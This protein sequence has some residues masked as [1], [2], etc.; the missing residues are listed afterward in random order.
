MSVTINAHQLRRLID[1]TINH[2]GDEDTEVL[3]G[4]R[5]E[6]DS[7]YLYAVASDRYTVAAARYRHHGLDGEPF[8]RTLPASCL[9]ALREW[10]DAQPGSDTIIIATKDGRLW[11]TAPNSELAIGVNSQGYFDWRGVLRGVLEQ[12]NG[13]ENAFPV[14]DTRLLAR[15]AAADTTLRFRVT[16]DQQGVLVVGKDFLGAQAPINA[17]RAR[18][19]ADDSLAT[20]DHVHATW[21]HTLAGSAATTTVDDITTE[22]ESGLSLE[23]SDDITSTVEDLLKQVLRSTHNLTARDMRP[24][25]LT[26]HAVSG[27]TAWSAYRFLSALTAADPKLAATVV[28]ET[29]DELEAGEI[30]MDAWDAAKASGLDPEE[31]RAELDAQLVKRE[32]PTEQTGDKSPASAA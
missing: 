12:T 17:A 22:S 6:A 4:I 27:V 2:I 11:F 9:T 25:M 15:F 31:W 23:A 24:E 29:A 26:A 13:A 18:L 21:Q 7:T 32:A 5:L 3:H 1:R 30:G 20:L 16:A 8:A 14:L 19:G 28:A 10:S